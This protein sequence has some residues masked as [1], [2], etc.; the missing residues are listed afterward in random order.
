VRIARRGGKTTLLGGLPPSVRVLR[1]ESW[2]DGSPSGRVIVHCQH[3]EEALLDGGFGEK[4]C[5]ICGSRGRELPPWRA[6]VLWSP[7]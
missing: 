4:T 3:P 7:G 1:I 2:E 6:S 5:I